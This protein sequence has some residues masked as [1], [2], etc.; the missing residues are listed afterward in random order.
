MS[1]LNLLGKTYK[2]ANG[3]VNV[4]VDLDKKKSFQINGQSHNEDYMHINKIQSCNHVD[5]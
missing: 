1:T 4:I 2:P 3:I 5:I